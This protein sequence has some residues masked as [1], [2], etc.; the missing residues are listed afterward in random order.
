M[1]KIMCLAATVSN[2]FV[3]QFFVVLFLVEFQY[4]ILNYFLDFVLVA[5]LSSYHKKVIKAL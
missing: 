4:W 1:L 5:Y 3:S 2:S